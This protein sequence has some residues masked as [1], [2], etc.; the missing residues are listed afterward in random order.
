MAD[1]EGASPNMM[2]DIEDSMADFQKRI[3]EIQTGRRPPPSWF[4]RT[5]FDT[6]EVTIENIGVFSMVAATSGTIERLDRTTKP[7]E[8]ANCEIDAVVESIEKMP[9]TVKLRRP[10]KLRNV[11]HKAGEHWDNLWDVYNSDRDLAR[12]LLQVL[13]GGKLYAMLKMAMVW[14]SKIDVP[15]MI[16]AD[17]EPGSEGDGKEAARPTA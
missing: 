2:K 13:L 17:P 15:T 11:T 14:L 5:G 9:D 6:A 12:Q 7:E 10:F 4:R 16:G 3:L 1:I 8:E